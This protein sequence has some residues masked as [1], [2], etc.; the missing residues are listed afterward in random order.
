MEAI[1]ELQPSSRK[2]AVIYVSDDLMKR[3]S[4]ETDSTGRPLLQT[5]ASATPADGIKHSIGGVPVE[6]NYSLDDVTTGSV[7]AIIGNPK[8]Y[9]IRN[10][11]GFQIKR[12]EYTDMSTGM[13]NFYCSA[14]LDG[15]IINVNDSFVKVVT[16]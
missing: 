2:N 10:V 14:R 12:D 16:A 9:M 15:K 7:S 3:L 11:Q 6:V 13:V 1:Y 5:N 8:A 4:L